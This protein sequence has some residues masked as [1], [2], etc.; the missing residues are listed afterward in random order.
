MK[1]PKNY[2][3]NLSTAKYRDYM[4]LLPHVEKDTTQ[5]FLTL[6]LTLL[7]L[8]FF[9]IFAINPTLSTIIDLKKQ[10]KDSQYVADQLQQ[11]IINLSTLQQKYN[12]LTP[13]LPVVFEAI[14]QNPSVFLFSGQLQ[15]LIKK[16]GLT[17]T[18][19]QI[20]EVKLA[21]GKLLEQNPSFGF[22]IEASGDYQNMLAFASSLS[23]MKRVASIESIGIEKDVRTNTLIL[24][25]Q[26]KT[27][28]K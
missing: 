22:S 19:F 1:L 23:H 7:A 10:L 24:S 2:F 3:E 6:V 9:G 25:V 20:F 27:Y 12:D 5:T 21:G 15:S 14:P 8:I 13:Q 28:F 16:S 17:L 26:G 4:K 18:S 11:K